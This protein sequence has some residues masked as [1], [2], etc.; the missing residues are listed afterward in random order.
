MKTRTRVQV[1]TDCDFMTELMFY[2][3]RHL[4]AAEMEVGGASEYLKLAEE[5]A[6]LACDHWTGC[7]ICR[8]KRAKWHGASP[9][10]VQWAG[11][12][13]TRRW[14]GAPSFQCDLEPRLGYC[15]VARLIVS[16]GR[17]IRPPCTGDVAGRRLAE[18]LW[19]CRTCDPAILFN[20]IAATSTPS[21]VCLIGQGI[22]LHGN[23]PF[24]IGPAFKEHAKTC[25]VCST[26]DGAR[27]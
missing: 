11:I 15:W 4:Q 26:G 18:H 24:E 12:E 3:R 20:L 19:H 23:F 13:K 1:T 22:I 27:G 21:R 10:N 8:G 7:P 2:F 6:V 14:V 16:G 9:A 17:F 5:I 25:D